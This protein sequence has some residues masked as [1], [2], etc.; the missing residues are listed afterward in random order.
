MTN[1]PKTDA[2]RRNFLRT[3]GLSVGAAVV[4]GTVLSP[5][6]TEAKPADKNNTG[7]GYQESEHVKTYYR[8]A[9]S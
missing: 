7:A 4:A 2:A 3:T 6:K 1:K 8:L 5:E 9:R